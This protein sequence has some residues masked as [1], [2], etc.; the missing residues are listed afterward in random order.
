MTLETSD[1][2]S[3][4]IIG[5]LINWQANLKC[6]VFSSKH[7]DIVRIMSWQSYLHV[8]DCIFIIVLIQS[9]AYLTFCQPSITFFNILLFWF[10]GFDR[11][12]TLFLLVYTVSFKKTYHTQNL[13]ILC[14]EL[15]LNK[16]CR[17]TWNY[18]SSFSQKCSCLNV[19]RS[20]FSR[21]LILIL[22]TNI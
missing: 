8:I 20:Y 9:E 18:K 21:W 16:C 5:R 2:L 11:K 17:N 19:S 1:G 12:I 10:D 14:V 22:H 3:G 15:D 4:L 13:L 7:F 6:L